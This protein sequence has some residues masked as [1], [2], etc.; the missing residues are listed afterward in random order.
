M[1]KLANH[2]RRNRL[3]AVVVG[4]AIGLTAA[5]LAARRLAP[6]PTLNR[7]A[8]QLIR[9]SDDLELRYELAPWATD[10]TSVINGDGRR[11]FHYPARKPPGV[12]RIAMLGDSVAFGAGLALDELFAKRLEFLLNRFAPTS[13]AR[14]EVWNYAVPAYSVREEARA[15]E[16][17]AVAA[18]PDLLLVAYCL[19][20][21]DP[22][23]IDLALLYAEMGENDLAELGRRLER[24]RGLQSA[25]IEHS[26]LWRLIAGR[27]FTDRNLT[28]WRDRAQRY[29][30]A[31]FVLDNEFM[32]RRNRSRT[33][34]EYLERIA[35]DNWPA[36]AAAL[37]RIGEVGARR[38]IPVALVILPIDYD[39]R[40]YELG[41]LH[42]RVAAE[43]RAGGLRALDLLP[44]F[45]AAAAARGWPPRPEDPVHLSADG[46]LVAAWST[47][48]WLA[49]EQLLPAAV[50]GLPAE[51]F[52]WATTD[53]AAIAEWREQQDMHWADLAVR[54][55]GRGDCRDVRAAAGRALR[56]N[57][58]NR[59]AAAVQARCAR[60]D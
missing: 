19:N 12:F 55:I 24:R 58:E 29:Y 15:A 1:M 40:E 7:I 56:L 45:Q 33:Y 18:D 6:A 22:F 49:G 51:P 26:A 5:E 30:I 2:R 53:A 14:F 21:P 23:S 9:L 3:L 39:L 38:R 52:S 27:R 11:D 31:P 20:D 41:G 4:L 43:A 59:A 44:D 37:R 28:R 50:S 17:K 8:R 13:G 32:Q 34:Q 16:T 42:D 25:L 10:G 48:R 60:A 35:D 46:H 57:P 47:A 54:A 36:V